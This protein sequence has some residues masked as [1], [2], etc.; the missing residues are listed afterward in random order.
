M[1]GRKK[2]LITCL[3]SLCVHLLISH[4]YLPAKNKRNEFPLYEWN[5]FSYTK[6]RSAIPVLK[7]YE[8]D[9]KK[10]EP[11]YHIESDFI[12]SSNE[13]WLAHHQVMRT[14]NAYYYHGAD[15]DSYRESRLEMYKNIFANK[16]QVKYSI[17][18]AR[19]NLRD[20]SDV[21]EIVMSPLNS[22]EYE[23]EFKK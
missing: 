18:V 19:F 15:S 8:I 11:F 9:F 4:W 20:L 5:L 6:T 3:I 22:Y 7:I 1:I 10:V 12:S 2:I 16:A 14:F 21:S 23:K 17:G 13:P